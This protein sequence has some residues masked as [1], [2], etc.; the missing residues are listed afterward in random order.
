M[1]LFRFS[2]QPLA[3]V[4]CALGRLESVEH[5]CGVVPRL[6]ANPAILS[7]HARVLHAHS[8]LPH[9]AHSPGLLEASCA[10]KFTKLRFDRVGACLVMS[11]RPSRDALRRHHPCVVW[12]VG[13]CSSRATRLR[14]SRLTSKV[15]SA[16]S[17][18]NEGDE[19]LECNT[20][21]RGRSASSVCT[22]HVLT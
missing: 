22:R 2:A 7:I 20:C 4:N 5:E 13:V 6:A 3:A 14:P 1:A 9:K 12:C 15:V 21:S 10:V 16:Q 8:T 17:R 18:A 19:T 11:A